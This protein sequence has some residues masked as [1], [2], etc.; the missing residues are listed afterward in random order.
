MHDLFRISIQQ[1]LAKEIEMSWSDIRRTALL[2]VIVIALV[3][4]GVVAVGNHARDQR[5][6]A[7]PSSHAS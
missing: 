4:L 3:C 7:T 2:I 6:P 1:I 5:E